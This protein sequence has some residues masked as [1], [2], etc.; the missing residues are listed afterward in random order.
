MAPGPV[1]ACTSVSS[2]C[3]LYVAFL[4]FSPMLFL[5][6]ILGAAVGTL[7][8]EETTIWEI[9]ATLTQRPFAFL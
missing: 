7:L 1:Y 4:I 5:V 3:I 9:S 6:S 8:G 2:C